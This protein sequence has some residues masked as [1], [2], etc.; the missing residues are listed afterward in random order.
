MNGQL[1]RTFGLHF[2][3]V[4]T[5]HGLLTHIAAKVAVV[6]L[7]IWLNLLFD[8]PALALAVLFPA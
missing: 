4:R 2:P 1:T 5:A 6:N 3:G 7:G 8:R